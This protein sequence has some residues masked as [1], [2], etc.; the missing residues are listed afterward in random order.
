MYPVLMSCEQFFPS[1]DPL[2]ASRRRAHP[3][4]DALGSTL[5]PYWQNLTTNHSAYS[6]LLTNEWVVAS[7]LDAD[8]GQK[9][10]AWD[11][12]F[13]S[14][15][16]YGGDHFTNSERYDP[17]NHL[18]ALEAAGITTDNLNSSHSTQPYEA[19]DIIIL[20]DGLCSST[21]ALFTEMM[22]HEAGVQTVVVGGRPNPGPMQA[23]GG[24]RGA[25]SYSARRLD[26]DISTAQKIDRSTRGQFPDR[27]YDFLITGLTINLRD[28]IRSS[29][30]EASPTPLQFQYE[31]ANCRIFYTPKTWYNYT[32]LWT[33]AADAIWSDPGL[34][35]A[36]S[37]DDHT[38]PPPHRQPYTVDTTKPGTS[39]PADNP[40]QSNY[41]SNDI[42]SDANHRE[43]HALH[44]CNEDSDCTGHH[45]C[46]EVEVCQN[47]ILKPLT[48]CLQSCSNLYNSCDY[49]SCKFDRLRSASCN[50]LSKRGIRSKGCHD[51]GLCHTPVLSQCLYMQRDTETYRGE[52]DQWVR[53]WSSKAKTRGFD[54]CDL[55]GDFDYC[56]TLDGKKSSMF[57]WEDEVYQGEYVLHDEDYYDGL[58]D[59]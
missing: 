5:T 26:R 43:H 6:T 41:P 18:F 7:R 3:M 52:F 44:P 13:H 33:Y 49:G 56:Y 19:E 47:G 24:T 31:A 20:T 37:T 59:V 32:N 50:G 46:R 2:A 53:N 35:V 27:R 23:A 25:A 55:Y 28:Q 30:D 4:A 29:D 11:D 45:L 58:Y 16:S 15:A 1:I 21:C 12:Y 48:R 54:A 39:K 57:F 34:C 10:T 51:P 22:H 42:F 36:T 9:F 40:P 38:H 8:T 14:P 17:L